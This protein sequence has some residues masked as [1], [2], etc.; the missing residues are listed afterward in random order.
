MLHRFVAADLICSGPVVIDVA[1]RRVRHRGRLLPISGLPFHILEVLIRAEGEVVTRAELKR[2]LWPYAERI[3]TER[4]LNTAVRALRRGLGD[5]AAQ[6]QLIL[7]L[8][9]HG[10]RWIG[11]EQGT[12]RSR[13]ALRSA[14]AAALVL[15]LPTSAAI[16]PIEKAP[17][18]ASS[19]HWRASEIAYRA[20]L[21][22]NPADL[23]ARRRLAWIYVNEGRP[24]AA[25]PQIA[26][27][28]QKGM[29]SSADRAEL[30]WL[31][32]RSNRPE[33]ALATCGGDSVPNL[34]LMSC[35]QTALARLGLIDEARDVAVDL[36]RM[37]HA[38]PVAVRSVASATS[39]LG[40]ARFLRW[41]LSTF[42]RPGRDWFQRAQLQ[43]EAGMYREALDSLRRAAASHDPLLAKIGSSI[44]FA[45]LRRTAEYRSI[46]AKVLS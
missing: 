37:A 9:S 28:L 1:R 29:H 27:L 40:Y 45:P 10:Y 2:I 32:L 17:S 35:R 15:L 5:T 23:G 11:A 38:D 3:D 44:E 12:L 4:R 42:V 33:A 46:A 26:S 43:A 21:R 36:M 30:G 16:M 25:L 13:P 6:P 34:N 18:S 39:S 41:R 22:S 8:R 7:T 20:A 31:L 14:A 19:A 24:G